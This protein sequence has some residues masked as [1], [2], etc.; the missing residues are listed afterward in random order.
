MAD[1][2]TAAVAPASEVSPVVHVA[3]TLNEST[4]TLSSYVVPAAT[5]TVTG[6][7]GGDRN[8]PTPVITILGATGA[9]PHTVFVHALDST[10]A[11]G[12][13]LTAR[14][15]W[16]FGDPGSEY[17]DLVGWNAAHTYENPGPYTIT[18]AL[19]NQLGVT[20]VLRTNVTIGP[21]HYRSIYVDSV[22]GQDTNSGIMSWPVRTVARAEQLMGS[23]TQI[24]FKAG[25][26]FPVYAGITLPYQNILLGSYGS[27]PQPVLMR[28]LGLGSSIVAMFNNSSNVMVEGL[29]FNSP[30]ASTSLTAPKVPADGILPGGSNI[31]IRDCTFLNLDD[32][33]N[34]SRNPQ[35]VLIQDCTRVVNRASRLLLVGPGT[36]QDILGNYVANSTQEHNIRTV[37]TVR[38]LIAYNN[39]TN[40]LRHIPNS[41]A[42]ASKGT[43]D[44]HR[45]S[46]AYVADNWCYDGELRVG[47][48]KAQ[49]PFPAIPRNGSSSREIMCSI[50]T[51]RFI[52]APITS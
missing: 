19:T 25:E 40:L 34:E 7:N 52:L 13:C 6:S 21:T 41:T 33:I 17:N 45:G 37:W 50:T 1:T 14:Y 4:N 11:A 20:R 49:P 47:P 35:G 31:T 9:E 39:L 2:N 5:L 16:D 28:E 32:A 8:A 18:L 29:T 36:D 30:W 51:C 26:T 22:G 3:K 48:A 44:V 15:Q 10:L 43:I 46:Y 12:T 23:D 38:Q 24:L 27:G 42:T